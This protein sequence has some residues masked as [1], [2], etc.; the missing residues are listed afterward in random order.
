MSTLLSVSDG[1]GT[2][3]SHRKMEWMHPMRKELDK[4]IST[5]RQSRHFSSAN[6][7]IKVLFPTL[8]F[9]WRVNKDI[10]AHEKEKKEY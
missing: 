9:S 4:K 5:S 8:Y 3:I 10:S 6:S 2:N 1:L 7:M